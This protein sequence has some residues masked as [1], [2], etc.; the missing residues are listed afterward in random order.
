[1]AAIKLF[2]FKGEAP[3][4]S[5]ELLPEGAAQT[6]FNV[7]LYSGDLIPYREPK[8]VGE[9][10]TGQ[11]KTLYKLVNPSDSSNVFLSWTSDV[12]IAAAAAP[13]TVETTTEDTEQRFYYTGDGVPKVSNYELA[14]TNAAGNLYPADDGYYDLGLP[15]PEELPI[16]KDISFTVSSSTHYERDSGNTATLTTNVAHGLRV[17]N[18]I[19]VRDFASSDELKSFNAQNVEVIAIPTSTTFKYFSPG[20]AVG[21]TSNSEG[22]VDLAGNTQLRTYVYSWL[23]PWDEESIPSLPS[24][25]LYVK[26]GQRIIVSNLPTAKPSGNNFVRGIRLYRTVT[27]TETSDYFLLSTLW[28]P[29]ATASV[30]RSSNVATV[31]LYHPHNLIKGD[32]FK[33]LDTTTDSGSFNT[34]TTAAEAID[35]SE[36]GIDVASASNIVAGDILRI[37]REYLAVVSVNSNTLTVTRGYEGSTAVAH[38]NGTVISLEPVVASVVDKYTFTFVNNGSDVASTA[39]TAGILYHEISETSTDAPIYWGD[40]IVTAASTN[41]AR[42]SNTATLNF[43]SN[44]GL[45][46]GDIISISGAADSAY[47]VDSVEVT[48]TGATGFTYA[49]PGASIA[50]ENT[51][52]D[53]GIKVHK[54]S[55]EDTFDFTS[56][57]TI[58]AS[59]DYDAPPAGMKGIKTI[60][61]NML[62]GFF[63]NQLCISFANKP[64]AW[65]EKFRLTFDYDIVAVEAISGFIL[66]LTEGYPYY[67]SGNSPATM[68]SA[69]IDTLYPCLSKRSVVNMGYGVVWAT[70]GGLAA[71]APGAGVDIITK[72][73]HDWDTWATALT[74]STLVGHYY[75]GKYFGSHDWNVTG[76]ENSFIFERDDQTGGSLVSIQYPFSAACTDNTTGAMYYVGD[77]IGSLYKWDDVDQVFAP[78][79]W[80]SKTTVLRSPMNFGAARVSADYSLSATETANINTFNET[81]PGLNLA[82]WSLLLNTTTTLA[83]ALD[84]SET[85]IDVTSASNIPIGSMILVN[86]EYMYVSNKSTNTLTVTRGYNGTSAATHSNGDAVKIYIIQQL[87]TINGPTNHFVDKNFTTTLNGAINNSVTSVTLTSIANINSED[88]ILIGTEFMYITGISGNTLTVVRG[89][90]ESTAAS[91]SNGATVT[92]Y[93]KTIHSG[94]LNSFAINSAPTTTDL[95]TVPDLEAVTLKL[96]VDKVLV[97]Q[98]SVTA[99]DIFRLPTGYRSDTFEVSVSGKARVRAVYVGETPS[100]LREV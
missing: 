8:K 59:N 94:T 5:S 67:V 3:R 21:S 96:F 51:T 49:I 6:A 89:A 34:I 19:T 26:E 70:H 69:R 62:I 27:S 74:P 57:T 76:K 16:T 73:V 54:Y 23:T 46:N 58:L 47:N 9:V 2:K 91:H 80:K 100:G 17:G 38:D 45:A 10:K 28:F 84:N 65:P 98:G 77:E 18:I 40:K 63:D 7:K 79:E 30:S 56:L 48:I 41:R 97:F 88:Y 90:A 61:N 39:D 36:T 37:D 55:F 12:D 15:L 83:E 29:T 44:H 53:T 50:D 52:N 87:G 86:S 31:K 78:M 42:S 64:H 81:V 4:L 92:P 71:Y 93:I 72:P 22:R 68:A 60:F 24:L 1:M 33:I 82:V 35:S 13:W 32:R 99:D 66:V 14:T 85:G 75:N 95:L 25:P 20:D 11:I 43:A